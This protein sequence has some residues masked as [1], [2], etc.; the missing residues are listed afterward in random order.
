MFGKLVL[1]GLFAAVFVLFTGGLSG[2]ASARC[3]TF[4]A[5]HNGTDMFYDTGTEG[6]VK[7]KLLWYVEQWKKEN[8]IKRVRI[9]KVH[10]TCG[11][12]FIKYFL[13]HRNCKARSR[14]CY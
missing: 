4:H 2:E 5:S 13:P 6:T 12:W 3:K 9:G 14:V 10:I 11:D 7:N 8:N 1:P